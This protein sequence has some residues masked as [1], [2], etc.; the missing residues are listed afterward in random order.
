MTSR[1]L[2]HVDMNAFFASVEQTLHPEWKNEPIIVCVF[3][4]RSQNSG[5][6]SSSTYDARAL[7]IH[8]SMP[9]AQAMSLCPHAHFVPVHHEIYKEISESIFTRMFSFA[10]AVEIAS[11]DE[12]YA[13]LTFKCQ[14]FEEAEKKLRLFQSEIKKDFNLGCS[15][16]LAPNKLVSKMAS[17]FQ[18][19]NGF[20]VVHPN[21]MQSF[22]DPLPVSKLMGV[23]PQTEKDLV[24][25][26]VKT[27]FDLRLQSM[28]DLVKRFG[29]ARGQWLFTS[30]RGIDESPLQPQRERKQHSRIWTL[31]QDA[32]SWA[33]IAALV[34]ARAEE[35]WNET[36]GKGIFFTQIGVLG[37]TS[38][39]VQSSKSKTFNVPL[40]TREEF[41]QELENLFRLLMEN[42]QTRWRRVGIRVSGFASPPKQK[43]LGDF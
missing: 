34:N 7:G 13:E 8:A 38:A 3:S 43:R 2:V 23:G 28:G 14:T 27:I 12:A 36:A 9:I 31:M 4:G 1:I 29:N 19:P 33:E 39:L 35:L 16:G 40:S 18:K 25:M 22:L 32:S 5:V 30:S 24:E 15:M 6:V 11:I 21:D 17:D 42:P 20:T 41:S 37:V 26:N 10:D